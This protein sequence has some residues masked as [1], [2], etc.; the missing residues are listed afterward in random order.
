MPP[1]G[2]FAI[3]AHLEGRSRR[4]VVGYTPKSVQKQAVAANHSVHVKVMTLLGAGRMMGCAE[5]PF[6]GEG[7][8]LEG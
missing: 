6:G 5:T 2:S 7:V 8:G 1:P 4:K 3:A